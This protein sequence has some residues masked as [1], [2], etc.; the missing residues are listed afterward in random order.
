MILSLKIKNFRS[1]KEEATFSFEATKDNHLEDYQVVEIKKGVRI[2]KLGIIYGANASGKS[3]LIKA[4]EFL[5]DFWFK[6]PDSKDVKTGAIPFLLDTET[7]KEPCE[8]VLTFYIND[9]KHVYSLILTNK[10]VISET[11]SYYLSAQPTLIFERSLSNLVSVIRFNSKLKLPPSAR[12]E[13][14]AKCLTNMSIFAA[15]NKVNV[16]LAEMDSVLSWI[17]EHYLDPVLPTIKNLEKYTEGLIINDPAIKDNILNFLEQAD[18]NISNINTKIKP[19]PVPDFLVKLISE[20]DFPDEEKERIKKEKTM[21]TSETSFTHKIIDLL[22]KE[23]FFDLPDKLQSAGTLRTMGLSGVVLT[24]VKNDAFVAVDE[25][26]TSIHPKL[27]EFIIEKFL[28][29]SIRSQLLLTTHYD[30]L[31]EEEDLIR[32]DNIWFTNKKEN[33][34]TELYSLSDFTG[35]NRISSLQKAYKYGKFGAIPNI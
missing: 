32:T 19:R 16:H 20:G 1:F 18:F 8:F 5:H 23:I 31:L 11:L 35:V 30:G 7:P 33:G 6:T 12:N 4:F 26:E 28:K 15:Y 27:V 14:E 3:N 17:K 9:T 21:T 25:I 34:S 22:G 2:L 24:M 29:Q 13:I 10:S